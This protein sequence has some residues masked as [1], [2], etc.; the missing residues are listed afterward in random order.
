M[1][2]VTCINPTKSS[3]KNHSEKEKIYNS[4]DEISVSFNTK[5]LCEIFIGSGIRILITQLCNICRYSLDKIKAYLHNI[6]SRQPLVSQCQFSNLLS[7][8]QNDF[9][10]LMVIHVFYFISIP[11]ISIPSLI[12]G[13]KLSIC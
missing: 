3:E 9:K 7:Q 10:S 4:K 13:E 12:F 6:A 5:S 11:F 2:H 8:S 1:W